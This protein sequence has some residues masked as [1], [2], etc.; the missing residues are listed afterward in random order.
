M[1]C[2]LSTGA[3]S[4]RSISVVSSVQYTPGIP[5]IDAALGSSKLTTN[6]ES[7]LPC[8]VNGS[9]SITVSTPGT[10][11]IHLI[12]SQ[13]L[14]NKLLLMKKIYHCLWIAGCS[15]SGR[16]RRSAL[17]QTITLTQTLTSG[18]NLDLEAYENSQ[19]GQ[20]VFYIILNQQIRQNPYDICTIYLKLG[21]DLFLFYSSKP[22][23][24]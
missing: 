4:P 6:L 12:Q 19:S 10:S 11:M 16:R 20:C 14:T 1:N 23:L 2:N 8:S 22:T 18:D 3:N 13:I 24:I 9:C 17:S 7:S 15:A 5:C 21:F